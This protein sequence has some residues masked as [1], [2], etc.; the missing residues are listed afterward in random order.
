MQ[1]LRPCPYPTDLTAENLAESLRE[2]GG[3]PSYRLAAA[4]EGR[5]LRDPG[6]DGGPTRRAVFWSEF[7]AAH[8]RGGA[9]VAGLASPARGLGLVR[10]VER[11]KL[12]MSE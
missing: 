5:L 11:R 9:A 6:P 7:V 8:G 2:L 10:L 3:D 1:P 12:E 4:A